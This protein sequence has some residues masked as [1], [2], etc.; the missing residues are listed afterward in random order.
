MLILRR[1]PKSAGAQ[2]FSAK[3]FQPAAVIL[4]FFRCGKMCISRTLIGK[5]ADR[6]KSRIFSTRSQ[7]GKR[8]KFSTAASETVRKR[9]LSRQMVEGESHFFD[10]RKS[11]AH[12]GNFPSAGK[13][14][15]NPE[16]SF[17]QCFPQP[18]ENCVGKLYF[19][20]SRRISLISASKEG[21][22]LISFSAAFRLETT[23]EWSRFPKR[24]PMA[25][26]ERPST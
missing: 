21:S 2:A 4:I 7:R 15:H 10:R 22:D 11:E 23:V 9:M 16:G 25:L 26:F 1:S 8:K 6:E 5:S 19:L 17:P 3:N 20:I 12:Q 18:V 24:S 13:Y 14:F